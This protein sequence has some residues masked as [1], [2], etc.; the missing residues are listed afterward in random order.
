MAEIVSLQVF[1]ICLATEAGSDKCLVLDEG[2]VHGWEKGAGSSETG[3]WACR[4]KVWF[5]PM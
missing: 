4:E 2:M 1:I 3:L 5:L